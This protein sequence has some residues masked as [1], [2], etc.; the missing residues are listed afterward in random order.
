[1]VGIRLQDWPC[2]EIALGKFNLIIKSARISASFNSRNVWISAD[3]KT[4]QAFKCN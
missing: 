3:I 1:M 2:I 4:P